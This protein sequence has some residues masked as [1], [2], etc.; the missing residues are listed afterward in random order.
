MYRD[1]SAENSDQ[2][3]W[4]LG[5]DFPVD[6]PADEGEAAHE[7]TDEDEDVEVATEGEDEGES[8]KACGVG[9]EAEVEDSNGFE[10]TEGTE[11]D[12]EN[13]RDDGVKVHIVLSIPIT[14]QRMKTK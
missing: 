13:L 4:D 2:G 7:D 11:D 3:S 10:D 6:D 9:V 8:E 12:Q 14:A 1:M 5:T